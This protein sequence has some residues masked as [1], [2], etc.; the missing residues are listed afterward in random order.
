MER[1][2]DG[3]RIEFENAFYADEGNWI[4]SLLVTSR[5]QFDPESVTEDLS[6]VELFHHERVSGPTV[7]NASYRLTVVARE[8]YPFLL[9]VILRGRAIPNRLQLHHDSFEGVVTVKEWES[10][11]ALAEQIEEQFGRFKLLSVNQVETTGEPFG[12]GQLGRVLR[13]ELSQEQL[14]VLQTAHRLGYFDVP[15]KASADDIAAE[16]DIAQSTLSERLRLAEQRLFDLV[17]SGSGSERA[18]DTN[19]P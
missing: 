3:E 12:S 2:P 14:T 13:N 4:E 17:F 8:P 15:R 7:D 9:G 16:L 11:R 6:R 10:F 1:I 18:G 19:E 5:S